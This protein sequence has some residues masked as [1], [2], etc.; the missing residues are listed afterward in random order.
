MS[1]AV[2][3]AE[4]AIFDALTDP[5]AGLAFPVYQHA[6]QDTEPPLNIFGDVQAS[7]FGEKASDPDRRIS[8][9]I[10]T[11]RQGEE[12]KPVLEE[13][14]RIAAALDGM[15][16]TEGDFVISCSGASWR[17]EMLEDGETYL[18]TTTITVLAILA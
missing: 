16:F 17:C 5:A 7:P 14:G 3:A 15:K 8:F 2:V 10:L 11:V 12:R 1:D 13:Q 6:P 18:G 9:E 4:K